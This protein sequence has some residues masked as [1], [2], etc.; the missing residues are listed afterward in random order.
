MRKSPM[1]P[2]DRPAKTKKTESEWVEG[3]TKSKP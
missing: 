1:R 2:V 3:T